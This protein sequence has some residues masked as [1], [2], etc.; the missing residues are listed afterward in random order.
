MGHNSR[1]DT[2]TVALIAGGRGRR[3]GNRDKGL[4]PIGGQPLVAR[5]TQALRDAVQPAELLAVTHRNAARYGTYVDRVVRDET[6]GHLGPLMGL[7]TAL[8]YS[9][10]PWTLIWPCDAPVVCEQLIQALFHSLDTAPDTLM[11]V[12]VEA[13]QRLQPLFGLY[14]RALLPALEAAIAADQLALSRWVLDHRPVQVP[15]ADSRCFTNLNDPAD[16]RAFE[17]Q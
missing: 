10:T 15:I 2:I 12:P 8:K 1:M 14:H 7:Y 17:A 11:H 5:I 3:M 6:P 4:I 16:L 13:E 9:H